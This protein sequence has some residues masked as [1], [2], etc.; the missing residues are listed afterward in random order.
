[1]ARPRVLMLD[2]PSLGLAPK[3]LEE[4]YDLLAEQA[5]FALATT[6][7]RVDAIAQAR[8]SGA[9][10]AVVAAEESPVLL[11][12]MTHDADAANL[13]LGGKGMD[14]AFE[15]V[16]RMRRSVADD[17][18]SFIIVVAARFTDWHGFTSHRMSRFQPRPEWFVPRVG[19]FG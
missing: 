3:L 7:S 19:A 12:S 4:P 6:C 17:L 2:E 14:C 16:E 8:Y 10:G 13:T 1:M 11:K 5:R 9:L 15:T 18:E